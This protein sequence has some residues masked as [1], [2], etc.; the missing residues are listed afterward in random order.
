M[1]LEKAMEQIGG[2]SSY[3]IK[4][5]TIMHVRKNQFVLDFVLLRRGL[6]Q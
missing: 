6:V 4:S 1:R 5:F 2:F 3:V